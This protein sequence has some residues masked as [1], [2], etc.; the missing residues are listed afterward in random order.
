LNW[1]AIALTVKLASVV[2]AILLAVGLPIAYWVA[3]S[4]K[5]W[6]F[7]V[8]ALV[9]L[10][11]V[12]PPTVLGLYILVATG[13]RS[14]LGRWYQSWAGHGLP[15]TFEGLVVASV[16]YSLPFAVQPIAAAFALVDAELIKAS[17]ILGA[18]RWRTF[19]RIILPLSKGGVLSAAVLTFAHTVGEFG[20]VLMVGGN[21]PGATQTISIAIYDDVQSMNY[22]AANRTALLLLVFSFVTLSATYALNRRAWTLWPVRR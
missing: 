6:K 10:P 22:A 5:R 2:C 16:L 13:P 11:L 20:V 17:A 12:L 21:I 4:R 3:F 1:V 14:P 8:E 9:A 18:S 7:L 19:V 15:F